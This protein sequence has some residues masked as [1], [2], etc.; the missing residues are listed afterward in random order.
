MAARIDELC[1]AIAARLM[2]QWASPA[3][4]VVLVDEEYTVPD[5]LP[6]GRVVF[7]ND[8]GYTQAEQVSRDEDSYD[9]QVGILVVERYPGAGTPPKAWLRERK[10]WV[11]SNIFRPLNDSRVLLAG[12]FRAY[13]SPE[14]ISI[15]REAA[16]M[17]HLF[18]SELVLIYRECRLSNEV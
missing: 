17:H 3:P 12:A 18:W 11:E 16:M 1:D 2:S 4:A 15:D 14:V 13:Q 7:V 6:A 8:I 10:E 9:Y 5:A